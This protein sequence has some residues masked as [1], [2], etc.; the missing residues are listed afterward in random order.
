[1][2]KI[3]ILDIETRPNLAY[4]WGFFKQ[5]IGISKVK[6]HSH[7]ISYAAKWLG[8]KEVEY[9][10]SRTDCDKHLCRSLSTL[11]EEADLVVAHNAERFDLP[12]IRSRMA[13]NGLPAPAPV[14][15]ID[16][17]RIAKREFA[18]PSNSLAYLAEVFG[19]APK[20][21]HGKFAGF[22]LWSECMKGNEEAW[23]EMRKYNI[24]DVETLEEVYLAI[25]PYARNHPN[26]AVLAESDKILCP[27]CGSD[28]IQFRGYMTTNVGKYQRFQ[29]Q[30]CSGWGR[31]R[32]TE[33]PKEVRKELITNAQ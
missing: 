33:Y 9:A 8:S 29:C 10:E 25:R 19:C 4:V 23:E 18:F 20:G 14:R 6:E 12:V 26:L 3:L 1:M 5:N 16:T 15:V 31:S 28:H 11:F 22:E 27:K 13:V 32:F 7:I 21:D 24:Q 17:L 30:S 2:A